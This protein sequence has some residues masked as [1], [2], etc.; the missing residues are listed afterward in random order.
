MWIIIKFSFQTDI[1]FHCR[2]DSALQMTCPVKMLLYGELITRTCRT[3]GDAVLGPTGL[4]LEHLYKMKIKIHASL[5]WYT[6]ISKYYIIFELLVFYYF[7]WM[8]RHWYIVIFICLGIWL[9]KFGILRASSDIYNSP[10]S[11]LWILLSTSNSFWQYP[12]TEHLT[13]NLGNQM[14][15]FWKGPDHSWGHRDYQWVQVRWVWSG[16]TFSYFI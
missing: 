10:P 6:C 7:E 14:S 4:I 13:R 2:R 3:F 9:H 5:V 12:H 11:C 16:Y 8:Q 15:I 1:L